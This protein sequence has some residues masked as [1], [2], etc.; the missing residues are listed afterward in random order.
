MEVRLGDDMVIS[1]FKSSTDVWAYK[2]TDQICIAH[3]GDTPSYYT[4]SPRE[5]QRSPSLEKTFMSVYA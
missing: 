4:L 5:L 1:P 3:A 2:V